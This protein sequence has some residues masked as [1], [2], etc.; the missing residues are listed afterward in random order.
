[1]NLNSTK[2]KVYLQVQKEL[3]ETPTKQVHGDVGFQIWV[4]LQNRVFT[5]TGVTDT[6][7]G[8]RGA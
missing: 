5:R 1:M 6:F 4:L 2:R 7:R 8:I 3:M